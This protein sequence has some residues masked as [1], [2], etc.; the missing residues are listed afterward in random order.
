MILPLVAM[1]WIPVLDDLADRESLRS[2]PGIVAST[3]DRRLPSR[4][5]AEV[6]AA[7]KRSVN[8]IGV[9]S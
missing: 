1:R 9:D 8:T 2:R 3:A 7:Q 4:P 5:S 6:R